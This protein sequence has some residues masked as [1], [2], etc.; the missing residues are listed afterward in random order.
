MGEHRSGLKNA[1]CVVFLAV[2]VDDHLTVFRELATFL[3]GLVER[4]IG[5]QL[6]CRLTVLA[7][8]PSGEERCGISIMVADVS[9]FC[10]S[11]ERL[12]NVV[13]ITDNI[14]F[15]ILVQL[16]EVIGS[17]RAKRFAMALE[18]NEVIDDQSSPLPSASSPQSFARQ[19]WQ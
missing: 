4:R 15:I 6:F 12:S 2:L 1:F 7:K 10:A 18:V 13:A 3:D 11:N 8:A 16:F 17:L 19:S 14:L 9:V 5:K